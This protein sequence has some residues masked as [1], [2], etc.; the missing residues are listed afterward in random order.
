MPHLDRFELICLWFLLVCII[1]HSFFSFCFIQSF[2]ELICSI[3]SIVLFIRSIACSLFR[4]VCCLFFLSA[5]ENLLFL[6]NSIDL[7][8]LSHIRC[9]R[10]QVFV[11]FTFTIHISVR[12][13]Q[14]NRQKVSRNNEATKKCCFRME[15]KTKN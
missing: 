2:V 8:F 9:Q 11:F 15:L 3:R 5:I 4:F 1:I 12:A 7:P 6:L 14:S 10:L 13:F